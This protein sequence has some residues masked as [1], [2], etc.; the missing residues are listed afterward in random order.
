MSPPARGIAAIIAACCIWGVAPIYYYALR[1][2]VAPLDLLAHR[3]FWTLALFGAIAGLQGRLGGLGA[4][5]WGPARWRVGAA[6]AL[7]AFN[8]G[9]F[10]WAV[11]HG[12]A[13]ESS[14]GYYI[15]PLMSV[16][17][18]LAVLGE[19]LR[20]AQGVAVALAVV[21]VAILGFG[22]GVAPV[23]ALALSGSFAL[24]GLLKKRLQAPA[25]L[26]VLAE[27]VWI[28]PFALAYLVWAGGGAF[29]SDPFATMMLP[30]SGPITGIPLMLFAWGG[31][32]VRLST[33]GLAQYL[34]PTLQA[35]CAIVVFGEPFT[36]WHA[37]AFGL[38]WVAI[39][40]Y[41]VS[42]LRGEAAAKAA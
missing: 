33:L 9:L 17:L 7:I 42:A 5:L 18:G 21:A 38:I 2:Q 15:F 29:G 22:L 20:P 30:L 23:I 10:I 40:V 12:H 41:S 32:R 8:W 19:R 27:V 26:S 1:A 25:L 4:L 24:Y 39:A 31:Q 3:T 28:A 16:A 36:P 34:N 14:L 37:A 35:L 6:G 13:V 11:G